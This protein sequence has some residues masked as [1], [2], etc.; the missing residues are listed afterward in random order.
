M[1][2]LK[3]KHM[4]NSHRYDDD[5]ELTM[6]LLTKVTS[7]SKSELE[8]MPREEFREL[9]Q[10]MID[11]SDDHFDLEEAE[12]GTFTL[13]LAVPIK[14]HQTVTIRK[15][16]T[17]DMVVANSRNRGPTFRYR[18]I[19]A[20]LTGLLPKEVDEMS[21]GDFGVLSTFLQSTELG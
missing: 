17:K 15:P 13:K 20:R 6:N 8:D 4:I 19:I 5:V 11:Q 10:E 16:K 12:E 1:E 21:I 3:V 9:E 2:Q 18:Q 14:N 7:H